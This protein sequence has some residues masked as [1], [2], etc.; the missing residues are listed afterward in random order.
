MFY[1]IKRNTIIHFLVV[2]NKSLQ[3]IAKV[4][5]GSVSPSGPNKV[6][7]IALDLGS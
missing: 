3:D 1:Q 7:C 2:T 5:W 4:I 6:S